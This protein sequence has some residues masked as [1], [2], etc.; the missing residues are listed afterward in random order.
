M[1]AAS[2][3]APVVGRAG[4]VPVSL[5][6]ARRSLVNVVR[7]PAAFV[8][9]LAMPVFFL[10]A[11]SGSF[12]SLTQLPGFP[13]DNIYNWMLPFALL[14]GAAFAG[15]GTGFGTVRDIETGFYDR[16]LLSS[17]TSR[18]PHFV[19]PLL[20][21]L[22]RATLTFAVVLAVGFILG[23]E[24]VDGVFAIVMLWV[25]AM[26]VATMATGWSLGVVFRVPDNRAGPLLQLGIFFSMFLSTGQVPIE[27]QT[28]WV[29]KVARINPIT[30]ILQLARQGFL[31]PVNWSDTWPGLVAIAA[32]TAALFLFAARGLHRL[33]SR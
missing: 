20:A 6:V 29:Q 30:P 12:R 26:G 31:G 7:I 24:P 27:A 23:L 16:M 9:I 13:T 8:P 3:P 33:T 19:G 1:T 25:A 2:A 18:V 28:G 32:C 21:S 4:T 17:T 10:I 5:A 22:A 11:F 14:Q 15:F